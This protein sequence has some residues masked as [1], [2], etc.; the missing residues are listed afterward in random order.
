MVKDEIS[1]EISKTLSSICEYIGI[2]KD[3]WKD[4]AT[5][6]TYLERLIKRCS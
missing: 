3:T 4:N 2:D 6:H 5:L 1:I